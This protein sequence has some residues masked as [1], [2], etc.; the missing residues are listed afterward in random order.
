MVF[1]A[2]LLG[3]K[4]IE[5]VWRT[6]RQASMLCPWARHITGCLHLHVADRWGGQAVYPLWWSS[7]TIDMQT[8]H[9]LIRIHY[10]HRYYLSSQTLP[11]KVVVERC[12]MVP[13]AESTGFDLVIDNKNNLFL[14]LNMHTRNILQSKQSEKWSPQKT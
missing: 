6:S 1:T 9:E 2:S 5:I 13:S 11:Q 12:I 7:L 4:L 14:Q 3:A 10:T 8:E